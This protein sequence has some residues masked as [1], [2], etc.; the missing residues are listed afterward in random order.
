MR[1]ML[2]ITKLTNYV[3]SNYRKDYKS[4]DYKSRN[5]KSQQR[6]TQLFEHLIIY[7]LQLDEGITKTELITKQYVNELI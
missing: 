5:C 2:D 7:T 4:K 1:K 6:S 3:T